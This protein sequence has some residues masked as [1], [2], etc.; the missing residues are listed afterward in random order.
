VAYT[1]NLVDKII[2][3][4][5]KDSRKQYVLTLTTTSEEFAGYT[6]AE[7]MVVQKARKTKDRNAMHFNEAHSVARLQDIEAITA[8][9]TAEMKAATKGITPGVRLSGGDEA[10]A[11]EAQ[12]RRQSVQD[13]EHPGLH[14]GTRGADSDKFSCT[15]TLEAAVQ[16]PP[17]T[18]AAPKGAS[19][20]ASQPSSCGDTDPDIQAT[21]NRLLD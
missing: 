2:A 16:L 15:S 9:A 18:A 7:V 20:P 17:P 13:I 5:P 10:R 3:Y 14:Y 19:C 8:P 4:D 21:L 6:F 11:V 1:P 12:Q